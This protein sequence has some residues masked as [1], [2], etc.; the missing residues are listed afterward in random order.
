MAEDTYNRASAGRSNCARERRALNTSETA[1]NAEPAAIERV[2]VV[3]AGTMGSGIAQVIAQAGIRTTLMDADTASLERGLAAIA[4]RWERQ[5][6][7]GRCSARGRRWFPGEPESRHD[8]RR[9]KR[10]SRHRGDC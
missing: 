3:G 2:L 7:T 5:A 8:R 4:S 10:R 1:A 9:G 6:A